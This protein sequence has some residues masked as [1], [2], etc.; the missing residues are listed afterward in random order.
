M[1]V[2]GVVEPIV[3]EKTDEDFACS[4]PIEIDGKLGYSGNSGPI[5]TQRYEIPPTLWSDKTQARFL[6]GSD[7]SERLFGWYI[8]EVAVE[9]EDTQ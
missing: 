3:I 4:E 1:N 5:V 6:F 8:D 7:K 9:I 2:E